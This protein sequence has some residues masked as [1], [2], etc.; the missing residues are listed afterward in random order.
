M[1][2]I[3]TLFSLGSSWETKGKSLRVGFPCSRPWT[4]HNPSGVSVHSTHSPLPV[5]CCSQLYWLERVD[6]YIFR[7]VVASC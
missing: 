4:G 2:G 3:Y 7:N 1:T 5:V 6:G